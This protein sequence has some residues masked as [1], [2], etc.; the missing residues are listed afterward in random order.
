MNFFLFCKLSI[1]YYTKFFPDEG[2][3]STAVDLASGWIIVLALIRS[4]KI[5]SS[6]MTYGKFVRLVKIL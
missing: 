4:Y 6:F 1:C 3:E 2:N 5:C